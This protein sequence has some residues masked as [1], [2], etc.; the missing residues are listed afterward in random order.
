MIK[1]YTRCPS[2]FWTR[3]QQKVSKFPP[4]FIVHSSISYINCTLVSELKLCKLIFLKSA[5]KYRIIK[6]RTLMNLATVVLKIIFHI[7]RCTIDTNCVHRKL[8]FFSLLWAFV[9]K[10][11]WQVIYIDWQC[12]A[13]LSI[14]ISYSSHQRE[15]WAS[16]SIKIKKLQD[17]DELRWVSNPE[18]QGEKRECSPLHHE[19]LHLEISC[20]VCL[21]MWLHKF[22]ICW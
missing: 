12:C 19:V 21:S 9:T 14:I 17:L 8:P 5:L 10:V 1:L 16:I 2:K 6:K 18:I 3:I 4:K 20:I 7:F 15:N 13:T 22:Q 11:V